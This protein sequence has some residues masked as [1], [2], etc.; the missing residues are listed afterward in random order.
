ME[1]LT[2]YFPF[3]RGCFSNSWLF[4]LPECIF[5]RYLILNPFLSTYAPSSEYL[6][7]FT[8]LKILTHKPLSAA[9]QF[10]LRSS[11]FLQF[12]GPKQ[13]LRLEFPQPYREGWQERWH[14]E[15]IEWLWFQVPALLDFVKKYFFP[16]YLFW[17]QKRVKNL[18][19][20]WKEMFGAFCSNKAYVKN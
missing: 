9:S 20:C 10:S 17:C 5:F 13:Q 2:C 8:T 3:S 19:F 7:N 15:L 16:D 12:R 4:A 11:V 6:T 18:G 1:P 14:M